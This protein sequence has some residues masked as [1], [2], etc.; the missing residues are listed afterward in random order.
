MFGD[1]TEAVYK[2]ATGFATQISRLYRENELS[3]N[4][5]PVSNISTGLQGLQQ[6]GPTWLG[7]FNDDWASYCLSSSPEANDSPVSYLSWLYNQAMTYEGAMGTASIIKLATRRPDLSTLQLDDDAINQVIPSLQLVNEILEDVIENS[8][9][10]ADVR[11]KLAATRYS[12]LLPYNYSHDQTR[13][14][15]ENGNESLLDVISQV[16]IA[17]PYFIPSALAAGNSEDA[18]E[19]G[20][21]LSA[22]QMVILTEADN[23]TATDLTDFYKENFGITATD[24]SDLTKI[25]IFTKATGLPVPQVEQLLSA[26]A[27]GSLAIQSQNYLP[28]ATPPATPIAVDPSV[29][30]SVFVNDGVMPAISITAPQLIEQDGGS[31]PVKNPFQYSPL[32]FPHPVST[33]N[34]PAIKE[35]LFGQSLALYN[36]ANS[37]A[38]L[39]PNSD[40]VATMNGDNNDFTLG[41]WVKFSALPADNDNKIP[42]FANSDIAGNVGTFCCALKANGSFYLSCQDSDGKWKNLTTSDTYSVNTWYYIALSW[43]KETRLATLY[44]GNKT[45]GLWYVDLDFTTDSSGNPAT[46]SMAT[47][48]DKGYTWVFNDSG[49]CAYYG[50]SHPVPTILVEMQYDDIII[51]SRRL[52]YSQIEAIAYADAPAVGS[53][54]EHYYPLDQENSLLVNLNDVRMDRINRMVRLQRWLELPYDQVDLLALSAIQ[55]EGTTV[56]STLSLNDNTLRTL[57]VFRHFQEKYTINAYQFAALINQITP[58]AITPNVPF[59]D[60]LFNSPS[61]FETPF[62]ITNSD[63]AYTDLKDTNG[64]IVKQICAG[65]QVSEAQ[66]LVLAKLIDTDKTGKLNCSLDIVSRFYRLV[67][68]PRW[69]GLSFT[70]GLSLLSTMGDGSALK[71]LAA[72]PAISALDASTGLPAAGDILS[73]LLAASDAADWL[74]QHGLSA[75]KTYALLQDGS[76]A[77]IATN[78]EVNF[79]NDINQQIPASLLTEEMF[80]NSG[81]PNTLI[82]DIAEDVPTSSLQFSSEGPTITDQTPASKGIQ[83]DSRQA[84]YASFSDE[85]NN[86]ANGAGPW[87]IG[88]WFT[89]KQSPYVAN[90]QAPLISSAAIDANGVASGAG[91]SITLGNSYVLTITVTDGTTPITTTDTPLTFS[92]TAFYYL[93]IISDG[94]GTLTV[95]IGIPGDNPSVTSVSYSSVSSGCLNLLAENVWALGEDGTLSFHANNPATNAVLQYSDVT[96]WDSALTEEN[97]SAITTAK[98]PATETITA[99]YVGNYG[100]SISW[101]GQLINLVDSHGLVTA[102]AT[103]FDDIQNA[104]T[105]DIALLDIDYNVMPENQI[106]AILTSLIYQA[107]VSQSGIATSALA[108]ALQVDHSLPAFLLPWAGSSTYDLLSQSWA[109]SPSVLG[110]S[111][112]NETIPANY[113]K[114]LYQ[115]ARR[116]IIATQFELSPAMLSLYLANP[117]WFGV[118]DT[119]ISLQMFYAFSRYSDWLKLTPK[120]DAV[121][122]YL[123]WV[124]SSTAPTADSVANALAALLHWEPS[125]VSLAAAH[126]VSGGIVKTAG[127]VDIIM[128][129]QTLSAKTGI[130]VAPLISL[131]GLSTASIYTDWQNTG[132]SIVASQ[133]SLAAAISAPLNQHYRT[134]LLSYYLGQYVPT[135]TSMVDLVTTPED[136]YEYLLI[137]PLVT[138]DVTTSRVAQAISSIQQYI[139]GI[140]FNMEPGYTTASLDLTLWKEGASQYD[141]WAGE[142]ELDTYPEDYI[143]PT[144]RSTKTTFF[145]DLETVLNQNQINDDTASDA[146]LTY[147]NEFEQVA[148][149]EVISGYMAG[150]DQNT[151]M[152]YFLGRTRSA[153]YTYYWRSLD[154]S[155]SD[156]TTHAISVGAW[157]EWLEIK[158]PLSDN[159]LISTARLTLFNN[160][161]YIA[162]FTRKVTGYDTSR[163]VDIVSI[164]INFSWLLLNGTWSTPMVARDVTGYLGQYPGFDEEGAILNS[165][166]MTNVSGGNETITFTLVSQTAPGNKSEI[167]FDCWLNTTSSPGLTVANYNSSAGQQ[168]IQYQY[169]EKALSTYNSIASDVT[170]ASLG[171]PEYIKFADVNIPSIRLNTLFAKELI[172][173]ASISIDSLLNWNTQQTL[174]PALTTDGTPVAMDF[175]GANGLYFWELFFHMPYLVAWRL[176][177]EQQYDAAQKWFD[178]IFDPAAINRGTDSTGTVIPNY[179]SVRP[180]VEGSQDEPLGDATDA[181]FDPDAIATAYPKHYQRAIVMAYVSN[182]IDNADSD[183]RLL[184]NDGLSE[185]KLRYCQAKDLLGPRPDVQLVTQWKPDTLPNIAAATNVSMRHFEQQLTTPLPAFRGESYAAQSVADNPNF[186]APLNSQLLGYWN[187]LDSRL[188]NLRHNLSI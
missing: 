47:A 26:S 45:I 61:L 49:N 95:Y 122:A 183:Y 70:D 127:Q 28:T 17:W 120:E 166:V 33:T 72:A 25:D 20:S 187:L 177:Q 165:I 86:T 19:L 35:G 9:S 153:P 43:T 168:Y 104:V 7:L 107:K 185:A 124:N 131:G 78:A 46:G 113:L 147:L 90:V 21:D 148:N 139:N 181:P 76:K 93:A 85:M 141:I 81:V 178:Y 121:L 6:N 60:Q 108:K 53:N 136:V 94:A 31:N 37:Y 117:T 1:N 48:T 176:N 96:V 134:G 32:L 22:E 132:E 137:D 115:V 14:A 167:T 102:T 103:T 159:T 118:P 84:Q 163:D 4:G 188:Y 54:Y 73:I 57:G 157:S 140:A 112:T 91:I 8:I 182:I 106:V 150:T 174:E 172:N 50:T 133:A 55:A 144:L 158:L 58:Y 99:T 97:I 38:Y 130:S 40:A 89:V 16:D 125:E 15:L 68:L 111:I 30:G 3:N 135:Q 162:W 173:K 126:A 12:N 180:L 69:L 41:F 87:T 51:A 11:Q 100:D 98:N 27:G 129:L 109:L 83:L 105:T 92:D 146:V 62:T 119:S 82:S 175:N 18:K 52:T 77:S 79:I 152:Y 74:T 24:Y 101:M 29:Y 80:D 39:D 42:L 160:R 66:F 171:T 44:M 63:F 71:A 156:P 179:W 138:N 67:M 59:F 186:V 88:F 2:L 116:G 128:R 110:S 170:D 155:Q 123:S 5:Q 161:L 65:L 13:L 114:L 151:S 149:L 34:P 164:D 75:S 23:S 145:K 142:M 154:M 56:N 184:T 10:G 36:V 64:R 169:P 143:D